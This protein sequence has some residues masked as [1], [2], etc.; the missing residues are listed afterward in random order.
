MAVSRRERGNVMRAGCP[1]LDHAA[2]RQSEKIR[3]NSRPEESLQT[4]GG[5]GTPE[6]GW[7]STI[8]Q[9]LRCRCCCGIGAH[10]QRSASAEQEQLASG[11]GTRIIRYLQRASI[12]DKGSQPVWHRGSHELPGPL[13]KH[14]G[15]GPTTAA[16]NAINERD[17]APD[18]AI[19]R[20]PRR[21]RRGRGENP[22][23]QQNHE[24][25]NR[26]DEAADRS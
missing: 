25:A 2:S 17:A 6:D 10:P 3:H 4:S 1:R 14:H 15:G 23:P 24:A 19:R 12:S 20:P 11:S 22:R 13:Q 16:A 9:R 7:R 26:G 8:A 5:P 18:A 21:A